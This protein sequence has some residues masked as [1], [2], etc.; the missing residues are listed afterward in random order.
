MM[1]RLP[2]RIVLSFHIWREGWRVLAE[3]W[4]DTDEERNALMERLRAKYADHSDV[5]VRSQ[6][7]IRYNRELVMAF[8]SLRKGDLKE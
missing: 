4:A 3:E 1:I 7:M 5:Y 6:Y 2:F 8:R